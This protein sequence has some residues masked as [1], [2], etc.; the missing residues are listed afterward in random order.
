MTDSILPFL[1]ICRYPDT[2][3]SIPNQRLLF[4]F[5][6]R[7]PVF[8]NL[9]YC[10]APL[11]QRSCKRECQSSQARV[12]MHIP[13]KLR[14][15]PVIVMCFRKGMSGSLHNINNRSIHHASGANY[16][17]PVT[18][19]FLAH[20]ISFPWDLCCSF[21]SPFVIR[22]LPSL[23]IIGAIRVVLRRKMPFVNH[24]IKQI[25]IGRI[26]DFSYRIHHCMN[27]TK[28][29]VCGRLHPEA[30]I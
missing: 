18:F 24:V 3:H 6:V 26:S 9:C 11:L 17:R 23:N 28:R 30:T 21:S 25:F 8:Q 27:I 20:A 4:R 15:K 16:R 14:H 2:L 7:R 19:C 5:L 1:S 10:P 13:G 22:D 12:F 29:C